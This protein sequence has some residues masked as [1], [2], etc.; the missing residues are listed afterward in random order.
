[1]PPVSESEIVETPLTTVIERVVVVAVSKLAVSAGVKVAVSE[2]EPSA[3]GVQVQ[4]ADV[5]AAAAVPHPEIVVP[6]SIKLTLPALGTVAV[7][8][9]APPR[10]ALVAEL[11]RAMV[12][13]V[14]ALL[15]V[16]V[17]VLDPT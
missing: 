15:T 8:V 5:D 9:I 11:G 6:P 13:E 1:M 4:V 3:A 7:I 2:T 10:A 12:M 17:K 14:D 16:M